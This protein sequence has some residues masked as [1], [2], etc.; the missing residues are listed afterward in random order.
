MRFQ[1]W[2]DAISLLVGVWVILSPLFLGVT[3]PAVWIAIVLGSCVVLL[4][5]EAFFSPSYLEELAE[6]L[7]GL[8]LLMVPWTIGYESGWATVSSALS[9]LLVILLAVSELM[10]DREFIT[11]WH[12]RRHHRVS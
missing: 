1:H 3:G 9:G 4:A 6:M 7:F 11:W 10:T 8:A 12:D 5:V 2:Q